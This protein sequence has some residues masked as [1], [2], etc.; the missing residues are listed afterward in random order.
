MQLPLS[1]YSSLSEILLDPHGVPVDPV[2]GEYAV[3]RVRW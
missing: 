1:K 3:H 2:H